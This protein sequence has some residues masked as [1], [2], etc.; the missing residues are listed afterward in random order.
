MGNDTISPRDRRR[1]ITKALGHLG[2][3]YKGKQYVNER[4]RRFLDDFC[5]T[6]NGRYSCALGR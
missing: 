6:K 4:L 5:L 1:L 2:P 3:N